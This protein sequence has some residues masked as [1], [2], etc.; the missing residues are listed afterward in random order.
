MSTACSVGGWGWGWSGQDGGGLAAVDPLLI[1]DSFTANNGTDI[2]GRTPSPTNVPGNNWAIGRGT[3]D[4]QSN[5]AN[6]AAAGAITPRSTAYVD[7]ETANAVV[8]VVVTPVAGSFSGICGRVTDV[9]N[10]W[11][12]VV[13]VNNDTFT[14]VEWASSNDTIRATAN[15]TITAATPYTIRVTFNGTSITATLNGGNSI[16][17]TSSLYQANT[18]FGILERSVA[19]GVRWDDFRVESV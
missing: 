5:Q 17:F 8:Q 3:L 14:I 2:N 9:A 18:L 15:V 7:A 12:V 1:L 11:A 4:I 13:D 10:M 6:V 19:T 16:N